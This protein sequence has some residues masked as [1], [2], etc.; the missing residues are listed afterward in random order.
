MTAPQ[1]TPN[2]P[3]KSPQ[4]VLV[5]GFFALLIPVLA[6]AAIG[7]SLFGG[8]AYEKDNAVSAKAKAARLQKVGSIEIR[9]A[10]RPLSTGEQVFKAQCSACHASG[11]AGSPKFG[12]AAAWAPRIATGFDALVHSAL[13]GKGAMAPQGG[14]NF[15]DTEV[16]RGVAYMAN[17]AGAKF[18][19]P[20]PPAK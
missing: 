13:K 15:N 2:H 5:T 9:D 12:D 14:G 18:A 19:E 8:P 11:A 1:Q 20:E 7:N 4:Q 17:A 3:G 10:N 16:A 6:V